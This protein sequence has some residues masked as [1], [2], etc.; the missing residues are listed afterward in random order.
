M[1]SH[2][3]READILHTAVNLQLQ[4]HDHVTSWKYEHVCC[5]SLNKREHKQLK[6]SSITRSCHLVSNVSALFFI[7]TST[8]HLSLQQSVSKVYV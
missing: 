6:S 5:S 1:N 7:N 3:L 2:Y 8:Q 4:Q